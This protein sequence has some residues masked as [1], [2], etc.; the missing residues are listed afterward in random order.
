M[1]GTEVGIARNGPPVAAPG[2]GSQVSSW[3]APPASQSRMTRFC[4]FFSSPASAGVP[5][6]VQARHVGR[7]GRGA[8]GQRAEEAAAV[9]GMLGRAAETVAW[10]TAIGCPPS[11]IRVRELAAELAIGIND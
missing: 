2:L 9:E 10:F 3:L 8:G 1:P 6:D 11:R 4:C 7:E 5:Q